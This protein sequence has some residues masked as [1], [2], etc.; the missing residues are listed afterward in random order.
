MAA[1][2]GRTVV[3]TQ[4]L[5]HMEVS[6]GKIMMIWSSSGEK[7]AGTSGCG[8]RRSWQGDSMK[9]RSAK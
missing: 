3:W 7:K 4:A 1:E 6:A 2:T 8:H 5:L 9:M